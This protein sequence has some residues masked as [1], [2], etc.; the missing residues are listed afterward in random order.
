[1]ASGEEVEHVVPLTEATVWTV[2]MTEGMDTVTLTIDGR[3]VTV[4]G[5]DGPPGGHRERHQ[6]PVLL[7]P[8]GL[9]VDGSCRVCI[10]KI[11]K[12]PKLQTSCST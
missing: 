4:E 5:Q 2:A 1:L 9:G 6:G 11:E 10:V 8:P 12:M 3:E 7:L